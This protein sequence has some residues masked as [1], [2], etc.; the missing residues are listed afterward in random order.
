MAGALDLVLDVEDGRIWSPGERT[1][2]R[3][4]LLPKKTADT[5]RRWFAKFV[6]KEYVRKLGEAIDGQRYKDA[7]HPLSREW[8]DV[9]ERMG[10]SWKIWEATGRLKEHIG[11]WYGSRGWTIGV[12]PDAVYPHEYWKDKRLRVKWV[13]QWMEYGTGERAE[14]GKGEPGWPGMPPR[15]LFR[16]LRERM[17]KDMPRFWEVFLEEHGEDVDELIAESLASAR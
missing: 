2:G 12:D 13:A 7:W 14:D 6:A 9:K 4:T 15:P 5:I 1:I 10:W 17:S 3:M 16:P 8:L 11:M